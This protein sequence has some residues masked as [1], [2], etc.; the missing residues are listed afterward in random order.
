[1][2]LFLSGLTC[3]LLTELYSQTAIEVPES[4]MVVP[5]N[6]PCVSFE[7]N[8]VGYLTPTDSAAWLFHPAPDVKP[9][10]FAIRFQPAVLIP[11]YFFKDCVFFD[12]Y[13]MTHTK[14][15]RNFFI[16]PDLANTE[17]K[18][19]TVVPASIRFYTDTTGMLSSPLFSESIAVNFPEHMAA[20]Y[21]RPFYFRKYEVSNKEYR[22]FVQWVTDSIAR[23]RL[24][25]ILENG[26]LDRKI[27]Y[28]L[29]D[30]KI[31]QETNLMIPPESRFYSRKQIDSRKLIYRFQNRPDGYQHDS[32][33]VYP[34]TLRWIQDWDASFINAPMKDQYFWH[35]AYDHY[36][37]AGVNYWQCQAFLEWKSRLL[38]FAADKKQLKV[39]VKCELP[40]EIEWDYV[41]NA[42][43]EENL[44]PKEDA[45]I[46]LIGHHYFGTADDSWLTDLSLQ[47]D[48][49]ADI[50]IY[51]YQAPIVNPPNLIVLGPVT[52]RK[53]FYFLSD[54]YDKPMRMFDLDDEKTWGDMIED[55]YLHTGPVMIDA[56]GNRID[57]DKR[58]NPI[59]N[60]RS[61]A[62]YDNV[63]G[64]CW[65]D[66]NVSEWM[67]EDLDLNWR[68]I[69]NRH[70][71][72]PNGPYAAEEKM[73]REYEKYYYDRLPAHGKLVRGCN[74]FDERFAMKYGKNIGG[75]H[76]KTFCDPDSAHSTLGFRYVI[77]VES[78]K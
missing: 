48:Y 71:F 13:T 69:F 5:G 21:L 65:M 19:R 27:E 40:S 58:H 14:Q 56:Y 43:W 24:G 32:L 25:Y 29:Y 68:S 51:I 12:P 45:T 26:M 62:H 23:T 8:K 53:P 74:W 64:I 70:L 59:I 78:V 72:V 39:K 34:D 50:P 35:P 33:N 76:A 7:T 28:D 37:V 55:G 66:G 30:S 52:K 54:A 63:T 1:M 17:T 16:G 46:D 9:K 61:K 73:I 60:E 67:R 18:G 31:D 3:L 44:R 49:A 10:H 6:S 77:Y 36:P 22:E 57:E 2:K 15:S 47:R 38:Q 20:A 42:Q 75:L 41:S 11:K 4:L